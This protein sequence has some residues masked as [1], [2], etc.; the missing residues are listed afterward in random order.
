M[1]YFYLCALVFCL[2]LCL[3]E[4]VGFHGTGVTA[5]SCHVGAG[6]WTQNLWKISQCSSPLSLLAVHL[7]FFQSQ[8]QNE[9]GDL[10][11]G[12]HRCRVGTE[13]KR[14]VESRHFRCCG[15]M[16]FYPVTYCIV[17]I[18]CWLASNQAGSRGG[19]IRQEIEAERQEQENSGKRKESVCSRHPD[20]EEARWECFADKRYQAMWLTQ[21]RI[22][23]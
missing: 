13:K 20:T 19:V 15:T 2:H 21:T 9:S 4:G 5:V 3:Y 11:F 12:G 22:M 18:K 14:C 6:N 10:G 1:I 16:A 7:Q 23:G 8:L 17:L